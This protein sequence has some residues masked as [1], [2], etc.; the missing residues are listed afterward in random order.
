MS[1]KS[2]MTAGGDVY[3]YEEGS[4]Y[5]DYDDGQ[6]HSRGRSHQRL[7]Y[8]ETMVDGPTDCDDDD[9]EEE[10]GELPENVRQCCDGKHDIGSLDHRH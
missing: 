1:P 3:D 2:R 5:E 9:D 10:D 4:G 6:L 8:G 7:H